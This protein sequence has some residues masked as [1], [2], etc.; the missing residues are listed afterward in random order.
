M[1]VIEQT[2][3]VLTT[4]I[5]ERCAAR[6]AGYEGAMRKR[7]LRP[8]VTVRFGDAPS[9]SVTWRSAVE[10]TVAAP[11]RKGGFGKVALAVANPDGPLADGAGLFTYFSAKLDFA[12]WGGFAQNYAGRRIPFESAASSKYW[13]RAATEQL[14]IPTFASSVSG[15]YLPAAAIKGALRTG[16]PLSMQ[17][18]GKPF[19]EATVLKVGDAYQRL[20]DWHLQVPP[21]PVAA[22]VA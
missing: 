11:A 15:P 5:L 9:P 16:L 13:E 14:A 10:L 7:G 22:A 1:P 3:S 20:T 2:T 19:D 6:A 12:S 18:V 8:G 21:V 17:I 4:D